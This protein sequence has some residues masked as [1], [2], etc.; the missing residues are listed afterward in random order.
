MGLKT[1]YLELDLQG[2]IGLAIPCECDNFSN[3]RNF[4]FKLEPCIDPIKVSY[5]FKNW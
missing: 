1:G 5:Y 3:I 2:Q 4:S